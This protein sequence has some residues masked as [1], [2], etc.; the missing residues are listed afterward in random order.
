MRSC[1]GLNFVTLQTVICISDPG[2]DYQIKYM[3]QYID[4][5]VSERYLGECVTN[6]DKVE[7][8]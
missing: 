2:V 4:I 8:L 7:H 6:E 3:A 5:Y 1:K